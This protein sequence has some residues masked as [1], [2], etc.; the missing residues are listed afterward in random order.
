MRGVIKL[1]RTFDVKKP[2]GTSV[3]TWRSR[4][5]ISQE[6]LA[7]RAGLHR[8]YIC[9][10]ERGARNVSLQS[11]EKLARA[12]EISIATLVLD[13]R[14]S[15]SGHSSSARFLP[16]EL[17]D[18][19]FVEDNLA[20]IELA[21]EALKQISNRVQVVRD[22]AAALNFLFCTGEY[23]HRQI[24]ERP[25]LILLDLGLPKIDGLEVLRR[26]KNDPRTA[27]IPVIVLTASAH[28]RDIQISQRL[29]AEA[30]LIKPVGLQ[31]LSEVTPQLSLQW[32]LLKPGASPQS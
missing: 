20:D 7:G 11:I 19:L 28:D 12:L 2:F 4:L 13:V 31:N 21:T 29:G 25:Q 14:D 1:V 5:G 6:E 23:E 30:Y 22:G 17:V 16:D 10:V 3:R 18:I 26:V 27:A 9:D 32:A 15:S 24:R 8:T